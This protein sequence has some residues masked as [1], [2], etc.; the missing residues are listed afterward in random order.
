MR[1]DAP[2]LSFGRRPQTPADAVPTPALRRAAARRTA[3]LAEAADVLTCVPGPGESLHGLMTGRYDLMHLLVV[4]IGR[5]GRVDRMRVATLSYN[6]RNLDEMLALL[7]GGT[8]RSMTLL[9]SAFFRDH[10]KDLFGKTLMEFRRRGHRA[11]AARSHAKV[12]TVALPDGRRFVIEGSA[13]LRTNSNREQFALFQD[14]ELAIWHDAWIDQLV[15]THEGE[16]EEV[17]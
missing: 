17:E 15:T 1:F 13:N 4:L 14:A 12:V 5:L 6:G 7:D 2:R 11:A 16:T 3:M 9:C 8:V 10:N